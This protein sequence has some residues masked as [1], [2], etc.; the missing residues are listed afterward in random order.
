MKIAIIG[1]AGLRTPL[2]LHAIRARQEKLGLN[3]LVLMDIDGGRLELIGALTS[4]IE[5]SPDTKFQIIRTTD[6]T[7]AVKDAD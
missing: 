6:P 2:L 7:V 4:S 5:H 3:E 1:A